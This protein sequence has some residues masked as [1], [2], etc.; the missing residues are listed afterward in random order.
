MELDADGLMRFVRVIE[1]KRFSRAAGR[2]GMQ[3]PMRRPQTL[4]AVMAPG[5]F[6]TYVQDDACLS[7]ALPAPAYSQV[8]GRIDGL[9]VH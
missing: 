2:T 8:W 4:P 1:A 3:E 6:L 5:M 9:I 7:L